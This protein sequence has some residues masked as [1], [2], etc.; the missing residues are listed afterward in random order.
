M[1]ATLSYIFELFYNGYSKEEISILL[2]EDLTEV[3][4]GFL[5]IKEHALTYKSLFF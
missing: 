2:D 1:P 3:K 4:I 5:K